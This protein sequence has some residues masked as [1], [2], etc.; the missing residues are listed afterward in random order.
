MALCLAAIVVLHAQQWP[1]LLLGGIWCSVHGFA[2][3]ATHSHRI[4]DVFGGFALGCGVAAMIGLRA[5]S[6]SRLGARTEQKT[7]W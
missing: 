6:A 3:F 1:S 4:S 7:S 5:C 2:I